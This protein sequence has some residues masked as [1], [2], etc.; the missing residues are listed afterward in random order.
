MLIRRILSLILVAAYVSAQQQ[1]RQNLPLN[2][3]NTFTIPSSS[4]NA[5]TAFTFDKVNEQTTY[6]VSLSLCTDITPYP[7][8]Y[9]ANGSHSNIT[10]NL[11]A[12][13]A[14][15]NGTSPDGVLIYA[16]PVA[17]IGGNQAEWSFQLAVSTTSEFQLSIIPS[18]HSILLST[19]SVITLLATSCLPPQPAIEPPGSWSHALFTGFFHKLLDEAPRI[20]DTTSSIALLFS[21][22]FLFV[23][24][25]QP[26]Y[27]NYTLPVADPPL[28][29]PPPTPPNSTLVF[30][31]GSTSQD[32]LFR[33]ACAL[34][35]IPSRIPTRNL[36]LVLRDLGW[37]AQYIV[38]SL[39]SGQSYTAYSITEDSTGVTL[40]QPAT[41]ITKSGMSLSVP[42]LSYL[43]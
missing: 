6:Y 23:G 5:A 35:Q 19:I 15:W 29:S 16:L 3:L 11:N 39:N 43:Y 2:N 41:I 7:Q 17:L 32:G 10:L 1:Q 38:E 31:P 26:D 40:S 42:A 36:S 25:F 8:F 22:A 14:T 37:K 21:P 13:F 9:M 24:D 20:G 34:K 27:P 12:G 18:E 30:F 28:P 33:S 4:S